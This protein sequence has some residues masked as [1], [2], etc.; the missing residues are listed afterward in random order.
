[1][2]TKA[3]I[4]GSPISSRK[5]FFPLN[6]NYSNQIL[7]FIPSAKTEEKSC[8]CVD[9]NNQR[10]FVMID[11]IV[12]KTMWNANSPHFRV[13]LNSS[14]VHVPSNFFL[15][16]KNVITCLF[17]AAPVAIKVDLKPPT[18]TDLASFALSWTSSSTAERKKS[19]KFKMWPG[20][21]FY[22]LRPPFRKAGTEDGFSFSL[23]SRPILFFSL[24]RKVFTMRQSK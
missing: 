2:R 20:S 16:F 14:N 19:K 18:K 3:I 12:Y 21:L 10:D 17:L 9:I 15:P 1:M 5:R 8:A 4:P 7:D 23:S 22:T 13:S 6:N 11:K 24:L